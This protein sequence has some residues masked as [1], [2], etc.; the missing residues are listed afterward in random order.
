MV[1][2]KGKMRKYNRKPVKFN[3]PPVF[4]PNTVLCL[5]QELDYG[6]LHDGGHTNAEDRFIRREEIGRALD[7][8]SASRTTGRLFKIAYDHFMLGHTYK[9][10]AADLETSV[11]SVKQ[12]VD[13][14]TTLIKKHLKKTA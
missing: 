9:G 4:D 14:V 8:I 7:F 3:P 5:R 13:H 1:V 10:I 2:Q 12:A 11:D 6:Y